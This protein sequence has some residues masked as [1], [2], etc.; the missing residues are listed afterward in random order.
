MTPREAKAS[1]VEQARPIRRAIYEHQ[2]SAARAGS[3]AVRE[4][5]ARAIAA[6]RAELKRLERELLERCGAV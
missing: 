4:H 3:L 1:Y 6:A 2:R 5:H